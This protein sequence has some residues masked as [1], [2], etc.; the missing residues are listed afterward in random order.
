MSKDKDLTKE[1]EEDL[2]IKATN[3]MIKDLGIFD[4]YYCG[5][6]GAKCKNTYEFYEHL[7]KY[8]TGDC[9]L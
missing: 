1:Q 4:L 2:L 8:C 7:N 6:C 3:K 5:Y 9:S